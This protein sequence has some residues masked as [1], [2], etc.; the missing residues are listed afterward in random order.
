MDA[1]AKFQSLHLLALFVTKSRFR[2]AWRYWILTR[3]VLMG[4]DAEYRV[5]W[6]RSRDGR[7]LQ[8]GFCF[9]RWFMSYR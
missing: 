6:T 9:V 2:V 4:R 7:A 3:I 8:D 1:L 5:L